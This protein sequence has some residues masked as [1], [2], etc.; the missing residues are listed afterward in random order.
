MFLK[1]ITKLTESEQ[2]LPKSTFIDGC[3]KCSGVI[4]EKLKIKLNTV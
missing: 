2:T 3:C 1:S 4:M